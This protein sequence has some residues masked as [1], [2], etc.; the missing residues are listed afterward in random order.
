[1]TLEEAK[2]RILSLEKRLKSAEE[3]LKTGSQ[4]SFGGETGT[5]TDFATV[6][7]NR[8]DELEQS[9]ESLSKAGATFA[10]GGTLGTALSDSIKLLDEFTGK[11]KMGAQAIEEL[12]KSFEQ[13]EKLSRIAGDVTSKLAGDL[14][15][16]AALLNNLGL[17]YGDFSKNLDIAIYS[18]GM[19]R[20]GVSNINLEINE[21]AKSVNMLPS[22]VSRNFQKVSQTL[23]YDFKKITEQFIGLQ[24]MAAKTGVS[25]DTL[26][27]KFG[28]PMDTISGASD[29]AAR[30]NALLGRNAFSATELL[31]M[32][33]TTRTETIRAAL[34]NSGAAQTAMTGGV[35]GKFAL[36]SIQEVLGMSTDET[37][38]FLQG[39]GVKEQMASEIGKA[40]PNNLAKNFNEPSKKL[41]ESLDDLTKTLRRQQ[42]NVS[43]RDI[44]SARE[45]ALKDLRNSDFLKTI[46]TGQQALTTGGDIGSVT[47]QQLAEAAMQD[48]RIIELAQLVASGA[49]D[50]NEVQFKTIVDSLRRKEA[51]GIA[52]LESQLED[53]MSLG[54]DLSPADLLILNEVPNVLGAKLEMAEFLR[55]NREKTPAEKE[56]KRKEIDEK[57]KTVDDKGRPTFFS[58]AAGTI[59]IDPDK[60]RPTPAFD[61]SSAIP[62]VGTSSKPVTIQNNIYIDSELAT[63]NA[64]QTVIE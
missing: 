45:R 59:V 27:G 57:F 6:L 2:K 25:I 63:S 47:N 55:T 20:E 11:P 61:P 3:K 9:I 40:D 49:V 56:R 34:V 29:M 18:F 4:V 43:E 62:Q 10:K 51:Q 14:S 32:D 28:R 13:F 16:Q 36:Q 50:A 1:M 53:N 38:R 41:K 12:T 21:L 22:T 17:S 31:M 58:K 24:S 64:F 37:R 52:M 7:K 44:V 33:E 23:A 60:D 46:I 54:T 8:F 26:M 15:T 39:G 5:L 19:T 48:T 42:M 30:L 35:T